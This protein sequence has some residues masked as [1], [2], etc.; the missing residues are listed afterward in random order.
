MCIINLVA[1]IIYLNMSH[2]EMHMVLGPSF[3]MHSKSILFKCSFRRLEVTS[4]IKSGHRGME[5]EIKL[6]KNLK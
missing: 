4:C 5:L 3:I 2:A 6:K 1:P